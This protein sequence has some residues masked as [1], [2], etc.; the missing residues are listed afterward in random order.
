MLRHPLSHA[1]A[2]PALLLALAFGGAPATA[3]E[4]SFLTFES[5]PVRPLALSPD[6]S[7]LFVCNI[8]D[9]VLEIFAVTAEG[10]EPAGS[11]PVGLEPVAVAARSDSEVWVVNRSAAS[12]SVVWLALTGLFAR[13]ELRSM[14][15]LIRKGLKRA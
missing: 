2:L 15:A 4:P 8:P 7:L 5:G 9:G 10:L 1:V 6:G 14:T 12:I 11:I 3:A 13:T